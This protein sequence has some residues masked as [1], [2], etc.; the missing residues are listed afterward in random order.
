[1]IVNE[2]VITYSIINLNYFGK[3]VVVQYVKIQ[4]M[5]TKHL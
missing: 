3:R 2:K 4:L 5:Y 1:M